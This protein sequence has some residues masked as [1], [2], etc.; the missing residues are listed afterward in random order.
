MIFLNSS[1][2]DLAIGGL[3]INDFEDSALIS[4]TRAYAFDDLTWCFEKVVPHPL[5]INIY[6]M[7]TTEVWFAQIAIVAACVFIWYLFLRYDGAYWDIKKCLHVAFLIFVM[8]PTEYKPKNSFVRFVLG[9]HML[10]ALIFNITFCSFW[11]GGFTKLYN[12]EQVA[13]MAQAFDQKFE[14]VGNKHPIN[15]NDNDIFRKIN[16][17]FRYC[18][19]IDECLMELKTNNKLA[20]AVSKAHAQSNSYVD[21]SKLFC[22]SSP[23]Q[24]YSYSIVMLS[25]ERYFYL[26]P[27]IN[28]R[29]EAFIENGLL[30]KWISENEITVKIRNRIDTEFSETSDANERII[31][32]RYFITS[33]FH[34]IITH[35]CSTLFLFLEIATIYHVKYYKRC[36]KKLPI[37][38]FVLDRLGDEKRY[39]FNDEPAILS[40]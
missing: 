8:S 16:K 25:K 24:I 22:F 14:F 2:F 32:I 23:E 20:V 13:T 7:F 40:I 17:V 29:L 9:F 36:K 6:L 10:G 26:L 1:S 31:G 15:F 18:D 3:M 39:F 27:E 35:I 28:R 12:E 38:W 34:L 19:N 33:M 4:T 30:K 5:L 37:Y 11:I 21:K